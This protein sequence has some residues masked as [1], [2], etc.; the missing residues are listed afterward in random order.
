M[1]DEFSS[2]RHA[3]I[4]PRRDGVWIEDVG[5]T[6]G[7]FVNGVRLTDAPQALLRAT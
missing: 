2:G 7:T 1:R 3:R 5:S 6:N 4:E